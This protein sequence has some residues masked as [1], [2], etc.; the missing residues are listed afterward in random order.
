MDAN[1]E[2]RRA[3]LEDLPE[4]RALWQA[5]EIYLPELEKRFTEFQV[6]VEN[7]KL[8]GAIGFLIVRQQGLLHNE[9]YANPL[10]IDVTRPIL[11][12]RVTNV[13][14]NNGLLRVWTQLDAPFYQS[15]G[16]APADEALTKKMP[17][18]L[19]MS[20]IPNYPWLVMKLREETPASSLDHEFLLFAQSSKDAN[21]RLM[22]QAGFFKAF[23]YALLAL[24][25]LGA[26]ALGVIAALRLPALKK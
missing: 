14:K 2:L 11:W 17:E 9:A 12:E 5:N 4:L 26:I 7:G 25:C 21:E 13:S 22:R 15:H 3:T 24:F 18:A 20:P 8:I 16:F 6:A 19:A 10:V 23:A 1:L